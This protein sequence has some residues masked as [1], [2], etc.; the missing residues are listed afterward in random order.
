MKTKL[1]FQIL[2]L[3]SVWC[4][5]CLDCIAGGPYRISYLSPEGHKVIIGNKP[6]KE[7]DIIKSNQYIR[8]SKDN[9]GFIAFDINNPDVEILFTKR[10]AKSKNITVS[11]YIK[12]CLGKGSNIP[13]ICAGRNFVL[14]ISVDSIYTYKIL[15]NGE[16][17]YKELKIVNNKIILDLSLFAKYEGIVKYK[18]LREKDWDLIYI[19]EG[20][21]EI[22]K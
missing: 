19:F 20:E 15:I 5:L 17:G 14:P 3:V 4:T 8:W 2:F 10:Q 12:S 7:G 22:I 9:H 18:I 6:C 1:L 11:Q 21:I 13:L 16:S